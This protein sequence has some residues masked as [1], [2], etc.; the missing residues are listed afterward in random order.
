MKIRVTNVSNP[1]ARLRDI[2]KGDELFV[3]SKRKSCVGQGTAWLVQPVDT[4]D[5]KGKKTP[6]LPICMYAHELTELKDP[7]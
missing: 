1:L 6:Q 2:Q 4:V 5:D 3:Y 7:K